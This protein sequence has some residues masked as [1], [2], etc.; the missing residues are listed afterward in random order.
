AAHEILLRELDEQEQWLAQSPAAAEAAATLGAANTLSLP[1]LTNLLDLQTRV[2]DDSSRA[3]LAQT[4]GHHISCTQLTLAARI[5]DQAA[6]STDRGH[7]R[8]LRT[9]A[10][11]GQFIA[12]VL[13]TEAG[14]MKLGQY[15]QHR[16]IQI[17]QQPAPAEGAAVE[18]AATGE[19]AATMAVDADDDIQLP[20]LELAGEVYLTDKQASPRLLAHA[21]THLAS[22]GATIEQFAHVH[23]R[24]VY[25]MVTQGEAPALHLGLTPPDT[26]G[27]TRAVSIRGDELATVTAETL[28][29]AVNGWLNGSDTGNRPLLDYASGTIPTPAPAPAEQEHPA[30]VPTHSPAP[31]AEP[32]Q[33]AL[34]NDTV[35][36]PNTSQVPAPDGTAEG[37]QAVDTQATTPPAPEPV[38]AQPSEQEVQTTPPARTAATSAPAASSPNTEANEQAR[39]EDTSQPTIAVPDADPNAAAPADPVAQIT[40]LVRT[41][42]S[43]GGVTLDATGVLTAPRTIVITLETSGTPERDRE[44]AGMVRTSLND[45]LRRHPERQLSAYR[46]DFEHTSKAGQGP[47][48]GSAS[49]TVLPVPRDRLIAANNAA[50]KIFAERLH[51]DPNAERARTYL[52][53]ERKLPAEVQQEWGLGYAPSDRGA[54]RWDLLVVELTAQGFTEDE[55]LHAGL[56]TRSKRDTFIDAFDDR[57]VFPIHDEHGDI[58]GFSGRRIDR[59]GE[60]EEQAKERQSQKYYNTSNDA[61][62]FSK[63][64][65]LFGLHHPAQAEALAGSGGPRVSV[66]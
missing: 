58:V 16:N 51:S 32:A 24:P 59:P 7:L 44:L 11:Q 65:L 55:L 22:G 9:K 33:P 20:V 57:I 56:A 66:E 3:L 23:G 42:L 64:E 35:A 54:R 50:A 60:T 5:R 30:P 13:T 41:A 62:L 36:K 29:T 27:D 34:P 19:E 47:L 37:P 8:E 61:A 14:E 26:D 10:F 46:V 1:A 49:T 40:A 63:G 2:D 31:A 39:A 48:P 38:P 43:D 45:A 6:H 52:S 53:E 4:L 28:L 12:L 25:A 21:Q 15:L 18:V 17:T